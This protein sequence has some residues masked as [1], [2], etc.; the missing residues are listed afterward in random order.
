MQLNDQTTVNGI[1]WRVLRGKLQDK[2]FTKD[3][4]AKFV[5]ELSE[6]QKEIFN[7]LCI[8]QMEQGDQE[9]LGFDV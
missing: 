1:P 3:D 6:A 8:A 9:P 2:K 4:Q 7:N 5:Q